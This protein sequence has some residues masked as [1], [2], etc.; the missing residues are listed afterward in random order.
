M[1]AQSPMHKHKYLYVSNFLNTWF[2]FI[3]I[4]RFSVSVSVCVSLSLSRF[5]ILGLGFVVLDLMYSCVLQ[6][7]CLS[8]SGAIQ[9]WEER[10]PRAV[11]IFTICSMGHLQDLTHPNILHT[12]RFRLVNILLQVT[13][14][15]MQAHS[16]AYLYSLTNMELDHSSSSS[17]SSS[18]GCPLCITL[19]C[20]I[21]RSMDPGHSH[22]TLRVL[23]V[24]NSNNHNSFHNLPFLFLIFHSP[25]PHSLHSQGLQWCT[26]VV[27]QLQLPHHHWMVLVLWLS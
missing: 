21:H 6:Q 11:L 19:I 2:S 13:S 25:V 14:L 12:M 3:C 18:R 22:H 15:P 4:H 20:R 27:A 24:C 5:S 10:D 23:S 7:G 8:L 17:S 9:K 16:Q 1:C 26:L